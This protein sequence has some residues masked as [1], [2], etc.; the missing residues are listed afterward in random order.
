MARPSN[1]KQRRDE[2]VTGLLQVMTREGYEAASVARIARAAGL[3]PGLVHY[4][5]T[6]KREILVALVRRLLALVE[7]RYDARA[8]AGSSAEVCIDAFI[9]AHLALGQGA[10]PRA[11]AAWS[12]IGAEALRIPEVRALYRGAMRRALARLGSHLELAMCGRGRRRRARFAAAAVLSAIEGAYR[13]A[14]SAP[15]VL[16]AGYAAPMVKRMAR[17]L[18][19]E[20]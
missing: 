3:A 18:I 5:F 19:E 13:I 8:P 10:D 7:R 2:I 9:D 6:S 16:P 1:T 12:V 4:H 17:A 14:A 15:G 11:V 20:R